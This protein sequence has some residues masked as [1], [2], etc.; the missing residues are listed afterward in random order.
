MKQ[1]KRCPRCGEVKHL[2]GFARDKRRKDGRSSHCK[3]CKAKAMVGYVPPKS[4]RHYMLMGSYGITEEQYLAM[5]ESQRHTCWI[6]GE[7]NGKTNLAV[8]HD[9]LT[10]DV[11]G[12]LCTR[13]NTAIGSLRDDPEL[14]RRAAIYLEGENVR[15]R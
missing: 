11:R 7:T 10:G 14:C 8:D 4:R 3:K 12:L 1:D 6:C 5:L 15:S 9:H 2:D 13:C